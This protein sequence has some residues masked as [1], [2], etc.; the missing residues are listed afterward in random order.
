MFYKFSHVAVDFD[1]CLIM[2]DNLERSDERYKQIRIWCTHTHVIVWTIS[3]V[4][5]HTH[6]HTHIRGRN[7]CGTCCHQL[8]LINLPICQVQLITLTSSYAGWIFRPYTITRLAR[9]LGARVSGSGVCLCVTRYNAIFS[10]T[11][12]LWCALCT[13]ISVN[14]MSAVLY[15][16][17]AQNIVL[18]QLYK[19][20]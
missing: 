11:H 3:L 4:Q 14:V 15:G 5:T 19:I 20:D 6:T 9:E 12:L 16:C 17:F 8:K 10:A 1:K 18:W 2:C 13:I 7:R